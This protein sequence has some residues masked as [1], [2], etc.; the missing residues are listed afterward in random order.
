MAN[1]AAP[2]WDRLPIKPINCCSVSAINSSTKLLDLHS[3]GMF[4]PETNRPGP[5]K[6]AKCLD[7][8]GC[9]VGQQRSLYW[10][11]RDPDWN[12]CPHHSH[13][14]P[15]LLHISAV[16]FLSGLRKMDMPRWARQLI[17]CPWVVNS[18]TTRQGDLGISHKA[19][20]VSSKDL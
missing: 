8:L 17:R 3:R 15:H 13:Q 12:P 7:S 18:W 11:L 2:T 14:S 6:G 4:V 9:L 1:F 16:H 5:K 10:T 19:I 20:G